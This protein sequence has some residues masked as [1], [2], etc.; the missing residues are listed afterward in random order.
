MLQKGQQVESTAHGIQTFWALGFPNSGAS[1]YSDLPNSKIPINKGIYLKKNIVYSLIGLE[2]YSLL[3]RILE[4]L[5]GNCSWPLTQRPN[6][7][8]RGSTL[9]LNSKP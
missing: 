6:R 4:G 7:S 8:A 3:K 5:G 2:V 1:M 9:L